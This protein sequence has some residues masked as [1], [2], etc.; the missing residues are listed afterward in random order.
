MSLG[1]SSLPCSDQA[2][3]SFMFWSSQCWQW[4]K[5]VFDDAKRRKAWS[6]L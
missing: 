1:S 4:C 6:F 3:T 5:Y 2:T